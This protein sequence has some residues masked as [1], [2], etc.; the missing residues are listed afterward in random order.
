MPYKLPPETQI[1]AHRGNSGPAPENTPS[2]IEQAIE[3]GVDMVE[4]DVRLSREGIPVLIHHPTLE[5]T[6]NGHGRVDQHTLAELKRLDAGSWKG[7]QFAGERILTL[8]ECLELARGRVALNLD[9]KTGRAI[10]AISK[11][12][13]EMNAIDEVVITGCTWN[14]VKAI[15][16]GESHLTV[17]LNVDRIINFLACTGS[18]TLFRTGYLAEARTLAPDGLNMDQRYVDQQLVEAA[19][20]RGLSVWTW[21]VDDE[22]RLQTLIDLG[23]D[24]ISTNWPARMLRVMN[25]NPGWR[26]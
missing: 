21:T 2:A 15:R 18:A 10:P 24:S 3:L 17:L 6:T 22:I 12:V 11:A 14:S 7:P 23:V 26:E 25:R 20:R 13:R 8:P 1:I 16:A 4:V 19:H 9:L 5:Q